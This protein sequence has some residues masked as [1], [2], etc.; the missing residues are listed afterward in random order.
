[1]GGAKP[2]Q[3]IHLTSFSPVKMEHVDNVKNKK[4]PQIRDPSA[5]NMKKN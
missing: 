2:I 3:I 4:G 1:V 5:Q